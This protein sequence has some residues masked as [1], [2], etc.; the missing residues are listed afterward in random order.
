MVD[1]A[2]GIGVMGRTGAGTVN[3][4]G[5]EKKVHIIMGTFSKS[6]ASLGG[7]LAADEDTVEYLKHRARSLI[8]SASMPPSNVE[9]VRAALRIM[10][11]EPERVARLWENTERM[12]NGLRAI[13]YDTGLSETPI[14][15]VR[16]GETLTAF[17]MCAELDKEGVFVNPVVAPAVSEGDCIIRLSLMATHTPEQIDIALEKIERVGRSLH[18]V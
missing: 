9:A 3:H 6:L 11:R 12:R 13:G 15:P 2:H 17:K 1:D 16:V 7:F 4:F 10:K 14:I 18:V 8:F 5:L